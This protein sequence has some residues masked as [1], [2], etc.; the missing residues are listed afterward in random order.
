[1]RFS[2]AFLTLVHQTH[3][4]G[5]WRDWLRKYR[6]EVV[7]ML[8][9]STDGLYDS[10]SALHP[11]KNTTAS[12][13]WASASRL[14]RDIKSVWDI[15]EGLRDRQLKSFASPDTGKPEFLT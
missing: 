11:D 15:W 6:Q 13:H 1:M 7:V 9:H 3:P 8:E 5:P 4:Q 12:G 14:L 2:F 10:N